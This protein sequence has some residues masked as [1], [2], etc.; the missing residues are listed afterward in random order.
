[1]LQE[2]EE[3]GKKGKEV[4][5]Y[6]WDSGRGA[7]SVDQGLDF[8][9]QHQELDIKCDSQKL[10]SV[11]TPLNMP[12]DQ[13]PLLAPKPALVALWASLAQ[14][15]ETEPKPSPNPRD[16]EIG[17]ALGIRDSSLGA[18]SEWRLR[19][20]GRADSVLSGPPL[21][22]APLAEQDSATALVKTPESGKLQI[23]TLSPRIFSKPTPVPQ[24]LSNPKY[25]GQ[26]Q[27]TC[28]T[29]TIHRESFVTAA[30]GG[31]HRGGVSGS[32]GPLSPFSPCWDFTGE[33]SVGRSS[34]Q[35]TG[36]DT[37]QYESGNEEG[38][39]SEISQTTFATDPGFITPR[40]TTPTGTECLDSK[41][42]PAQDLSSFN[43]TLLKYEV[44]LAMKTMLYGLAGQVGS[45]K[46][47]SWDSC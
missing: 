3:G 39:E 9:S 2:R 46:G 36:S 10:H 31:M 34:Y 11:E 20:G 4:V 30:E 29:S 19:P 5:G 32:S 13:A 7:I 18:G 42:G 43:R 44:E 35:S 26:T 6:G 24:P 15:T 38:Y 17:I 22:Q 16:S 12:P 41:R 27:A 28:L 45:P 47:L 8:D 40:S 21:P 14:K 33:H 23:P 37:V 25:V 1:M